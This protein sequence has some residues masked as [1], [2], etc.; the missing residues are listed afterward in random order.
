MK[1]TTCRFSP[2]SLCVSFWTKYTCSF[3]TLHSRTFTNLLLCEGQVT[4]AETMLLILVW[5]TARC[6]Y[7]QA[8]ESEHSVAGI[9]VR[10]ADCGRFQQLFEVLSDVLHFLQMH[11][12]IFQ[13][14]DHVRVSGTK[15][16]RV[17]CL[18]ASQERV[19]LI[20]EPSLYSSLV[21]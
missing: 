13:A 5:D 16:E 14:V 20:S 7:S 21:C 10:T 6:I 9:A 11:Q 4:E 3:L 18:S 12:F 2:T 19:T 1:V 8:R 15:K 17:T